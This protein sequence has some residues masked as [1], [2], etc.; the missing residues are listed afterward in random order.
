MD[1]ALLKHDAEKI[2]PETVAREVR[3]P[4]GFSCLSGLFGLFG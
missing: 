3:E 4:E 1:L 2:P